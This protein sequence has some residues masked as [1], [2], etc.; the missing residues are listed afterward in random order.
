MAGQEG[1]EPPALGFGVRCSTVGAT[2]LRTRLAGQGG[3][4]RHAARQLLGFLVQ[5]MCFAE[6]TKLL[7]L[8]LVRNCPFIF[9]RRVIALLTVFARKCYYVSHILF[10]SC[11]PA[12]QPQPYSMILVM[13]PAPTVRP[14]SRIAK[15]RPSSIAIGVINSPAICTL[16]PGITISTPSSSV[17]TP[18][19][20]VVRK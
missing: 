12:G 16:S 3:G 6:R 1:F 7:Q 20:S 11:V 14:P 17:H 19:T 10:L 13:T 5:G 18:V 2:G 15:R 9:R 4:I 8:E